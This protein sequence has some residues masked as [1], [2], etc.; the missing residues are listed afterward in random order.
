MELADVAFA[1]SRIYSILAKC[2]KYPSGTPWDYMAKPDEEDFKR[3]EQLEALFGLK[4]LVKNFKRLVEMIDLMPTVTERAEYTKLFASTRLESG[5]CPPREENYVEKVED[6]KSVKNAYRE[7]GLDLSEEL[8]EV[9]D[10][11]A[12]ELEFMHI[13]AY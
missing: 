12:A 2:F 7:F 9:P 8:R 13:L 6:V 1:R 11:I 5:Q 4:D 3:I 10:H